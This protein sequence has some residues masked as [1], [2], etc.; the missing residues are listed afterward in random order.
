[1]LEPLP[2]SMINQPLQHNLN[3]LPKDTF[4][5]DEVDVHALERTFDLVHFFNDVDVGITLEDFNLKKRLRPFV[6][7][8]TFDAAE[9]AERA[10]EYVAVVEG[11]YLPFFGVASRLDK[12]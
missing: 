3:L 8:A 6:P 4:I 10:Q 5:Y 9:A 12:I 2:S 7:V 1:M 11:T